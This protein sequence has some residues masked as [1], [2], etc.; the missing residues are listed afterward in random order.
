VHSVLILLERSLSKAGITIETDLTPEAHASGYPAELRQV[1]TNLL[2]NAADASKPGSTIRVSVY[3]Q[4]AE[5]TEAE[6][7]ATIAGVVVK[8]A[9]HGTG[10]PPAIRDDL[11]RPFFTTKGEQGSGL[12][13]WITKGI[14]EKHA[15]TITVDSTVAR[16]EAPD[17]HGTTFTIFLPRGVASSNAIDPG[18]T[19]AAITAQTPE[20]VAAA[21]APITR[22]TGALGVPTGRRLRGGLKRDTKDVNPQMPSHE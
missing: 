6:E 7:F 14:V 20:L 17:D 12:G 16:P 13:L 10:I 5:K 2:T 22:V 21:P 4:A 19:E 1:F 8:V 15:G 3:N 18:I 9:D 11:F